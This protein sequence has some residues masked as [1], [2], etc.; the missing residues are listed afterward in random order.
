MA[1]DSGLWDVNFTLTVGGEDLSN[2]LIS[3]MYKSSLCAPSAILELTLAPDME[4]D[5]IPYETVTVSIDGTLVF[6]G[7]TQKEVMARRPVAQ[8]VDCE[9]ALSKVRDTWS[10]DQDLEANGESTSYWI[11]YFL[12]LAGVSKSVAGG[13]PPIPQKRWGVINCYQAIVGMLKLVNWTI[14]VR[15]DG[16]VE[17]THHIKNEGAAITVKHTSWERTIDDSWLRNRAVVLGRNEES[18]VMLDNYVPEIAGEI[19]AA[20]VASPDIIWPGTAYAMANIILNEFS[21]PLDMIVLE[22]P[23]NPEINIADTVYVTDSWENHSRYG[24]VTGLQWRLNAKDGYKMTLS[25]DE[26]CP[27]FWMVDME[28][29][30]LYCALEGGG[31]WKSFNDGESWFDI[32]GEELNEG[33]AS[34]AKDIHVIKGLSL[35]SSDDTVW[36]ATLGGIFKTETGA[37]PWINITEEYMDTR[38]QGMDWWG[39]RVSPIDHDRIY[40]LGNA[41]EGATQIVDGEGNLLGTIPPHSSI[42]IYTSLDGGETWTGYPVNSY[43][44]SV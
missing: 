42:W 44:F 11:N 20:I 22:C 17:I 6:T 3:G 25:L 35:I 32:S 23:G 24:K 41:P 1:L 37:N 10:Y 26:R 21:T 34:Y 18:S 16:T 31:V 39:I 7:Y 33:S 15:P 19:R 13:G 14:R 43:D 38:A 4:R 12:D 40:C 29:V 30:V 5:V 8:T 9:D 2:W 27:S 36:A 28:P